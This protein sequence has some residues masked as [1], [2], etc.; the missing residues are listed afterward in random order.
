MTQTIAARAALLDMDGTLVDSTAVVERLW[1]AWAEPH[2]IDPETVLRTV[3][4]R[5]GHQS[6]AIMLPERDHAI[7]LH[8]ND[9]MLAN[10]AGDVDGVIEIPGARALLDALHPFPHAI[11]TSANVALMTARMRAAGLSVPERKVTAEDVSASKPDPEGFLRAAEILGI[12]PADCVVFEDSG[13][14]IQ[15]GL[16]AGMRV[17]GVGKHAAAHHPTVLVTDLSQVSVAATPDGFE[18]TID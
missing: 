15:A 13:A 2:G 3:H 8:E 12:D 9:I 11:V 16:A 4:G 18:L 7:N 5:Q 17:I 1:L 14:G 6:M 10:E